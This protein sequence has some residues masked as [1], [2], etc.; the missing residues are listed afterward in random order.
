MKFKKIVGFGDSWMWGDEL[1]S[2]ELRDAPHS[3]PVLESNTSY[4]EQNC[5]LGLL[6]QHYGLPTENFGIAGGSLQSTIW[7]YLWWLKNEPLPIEDCLILVALTDP[8]RY[9][10]YNPDHVSYENDPPWNRFVH[11]AWI[12]SVSDCYNEQWTGTVKNLFALS[13]CQQLQQLNFDQ[14]VYF[15]EGQSSV[16]N[17][18][19]VQFSCATKFTSTQPVSSMFSNGST[20][21]SLI[22]QRPNS[23]AFFAP[24]RHPNEQGHQLIAQY[25]INHL[26]SCIIKG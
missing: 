23:Q 21:R 6:G 4:R 7:T 20:L 17:K 25:L 24:K 14:T 15:F 19:V 13:D 8:G 18:N 3:H 10:F 1:L 16:H 2:P 9:S 11:S 12:R 22:D 5:F 26:D